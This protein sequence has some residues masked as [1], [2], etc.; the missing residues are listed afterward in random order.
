[1][2]T[3]T[4]RIAGVGIQLE[5]DQELAVTEEFKPFLENGSD[6]CYRAVFH[7]V[8]A[9][10]EIPRETVFLDHCCATHPDGKGGY[11]RSFFDAPRDLE[12]YSL[13]TYDFRTKVI[14][15]P[16]LEKGSSCVSQMSNSFFHIGLEGILIHENRLSYH[17][18]CV[19]TP[20]GGILFAGPSG[21]GKSTQADLWR[22]HRGGRLI[23]GDRPILSLDDKGVLAWGSPY[24]GSSRCY[25]N[26]NCRVAAIVL[27]KQA[28]EC[29]IRRLG[30]SEAVRRIFV[31][32]NVHNWDRFFVTR[33]CDLVVEVASKVPVY[34]F[35][36]TPDESA[37]DFLE[38]A[39]KEGTKL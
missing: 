32:L 14:D 26:E 34:E 4:F 37:V 1:M 17:A 38:N 18:S 9:I 22:R 28:P 10:P 7:R 31:G 21:T 16:Y 20:L 29:C 15:I 23:N 8:E 30:L 33:A 5:S 6:S 39:L 2:S 25:R 36:C 13:V 3:H 24:A 35:A 27:L 12:P 11:L 19:D